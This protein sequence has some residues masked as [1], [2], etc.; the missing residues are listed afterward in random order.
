[1]LGMASF[2]CNERTEEVHMYWSEFLSTATYSRSNLSRGDTSRRLDPKW[3]HL[4]R[5]QRSGPH[6]NH[7]ALSS[8][9]KLSGAHHRGP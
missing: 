5:T 8:S 6:L 2:L 9:K 3:R 4:A 7:Q 1:M